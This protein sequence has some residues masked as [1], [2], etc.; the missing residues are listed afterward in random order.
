MQIEDQGRSNKQRNYILSNIWG[1]NTAHIDSLAYEINSD[2]LY[3]TNNPAFLRHDW[4]Q[5]YHRK[6]FSSSKE[7]S[8]KDN[9]NQ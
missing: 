5:N 7:Q 2:Y 8:A 9:N 3:K 6:I 1:F 4:F